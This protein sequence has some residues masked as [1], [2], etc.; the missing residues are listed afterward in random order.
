MF[1]CLDFHLRVAETQHNGNEPPSLWTNKTS[2]IKEKCRFKTLK[3]FINAVMV[4][5]IYCY[6]PLLCV[7]DR[8]DTFV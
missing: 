5:D 7:I 4:I 2:T 1:S 3:K 6:K 8:E